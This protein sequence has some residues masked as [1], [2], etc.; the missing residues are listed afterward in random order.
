MSVDCVHRVVVSGVS[1]CMG[2]GAI[3]R[4][5]FLCVDHGGIVGCMRVCVLCV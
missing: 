2:I 5:M 4:V 3:D 1:Y